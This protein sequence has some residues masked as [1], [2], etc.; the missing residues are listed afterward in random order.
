MD[1]LMHDIRYAFTVLRRNKGFAATALLTL[2]L[3]IGATTAV[4]FGRLR[5]CSCGPLP[6]PTADRL[7]RLSEEHPGA[8]SPL[9]QPM[10]SNLTYHAWAQGVADHR[11]IRGIRDQ[12]IHTHPARRR[13]PASPAHRSRPPCSQCSARRRRSAASSATMKES[14]GGTVYVVFVGLRLGAKYFGGDPAIVGRG[15]EIDGKPATVIGVA[16]PTFN[17]P[18]TDTLIWTPDG[19]CSGRRPMPWPAAAV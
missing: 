13:H 18:A 6:Y 14:S 3:G 10:L 7:V 11:A 15:I 1:T 4:F 19:G 9:R 5:A 16:R 17:F 12:A 2:A 8:A